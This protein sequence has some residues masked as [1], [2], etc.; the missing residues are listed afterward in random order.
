MYWPALHLELGAQCVHCWLLVAYGRKAK[1]GKLKTLNRAVV[2]NFART[3]LGH[4]VRCVF[5]G[6]QILQQVVPVVLI[7]P[8]E[9]KTK[10]KHPKRPQWVIPICL[11]AF[12]LH[13]E[14]S[15]S[16]GEQMPT[17]ACTAQPSC[18]IDE[19]RRDLH[20]QCK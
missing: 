19:G 2:R 18:I 6:H 13:S 3:D 17:T 15:A 20:N 11:L 4:K 9:N 8:V 16:A 10:T 5:D 1:A 14:S 12:R 7:G